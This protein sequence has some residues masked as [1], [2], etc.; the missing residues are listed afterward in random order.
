MRAQTQLAPLFIFASVRLIRVSYRFF[1]FVAY[2]T[3]VALQ[4][5]A[6]RRWLTLGTAQIME[7]RRRWARRLLSISGVRVVVEGSAP[8][9]PCL[10]LANH[11]SY[12]DPI[13]LLRDVHAYPVAK[14]ELSHWPIIGRGARHAG[15][16]YLQREHASSGGLALK[17]VVDAVLQEGFSVILFPEGTTSDQ[18]RLLPLKKGAFRAAARWSLP[19]VPVAICFQDPRDFWVGSEPFLRHAWRRFQEREIVVRLCYGPIFCHSD[20]HLLEQETRRWIEAQLGVF[21]QV[22]RPAQ[23]H[24]C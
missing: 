5:Y 3:L 9:R 18:G 4:M 2:T 10:L 8:T 15:I 20:A 14:A 16:I 13:L 24:E 17:A 7:M 12:L 6:A 11:R 19:V 23:G 1:F 21:H 22:H